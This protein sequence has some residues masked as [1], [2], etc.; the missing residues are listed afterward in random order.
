MTKLVEA[1]ERRAILRCPDYDES[2]TYW[3]EVDDLLAEQDTLMNKIRSFNNEI[4]ILK[5]S[6]FA[7]S[8]FLNNPSP[9]KKRK[10]SAVEGNDS[11]DD[12]D[13][14]SEICSSVAKVVGV[15]KE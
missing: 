5:P 1:A 11:M 8:D 12:S 13:D 2:N 14:V 4:T 9:S 7:V 10:A 15:S 3:K 6:S